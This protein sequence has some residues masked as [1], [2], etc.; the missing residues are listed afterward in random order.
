MLIRIVFLFCFLLLNFIWGQ[1]KPNV[2]MIIVDDLNDLPLHPE[3]KPQAKTPNIDR[4]SKQ[5]VNF[6]N[7]HCNNP[8]CEPSRNSLF[9]G[10]YPQT[11]GLHWFEHS[12]KNEILKNS[13]P[14]QEHLQSNGYQAFGT[15]KIFHST[16]RNNSFDEWG[17]D[18]NYGPWP[19][20]GRQKSRYGFL[21]HPSQSDFLKASAD[22]PF[23]WEHCFGT[24]EKVPHWAPDPKNNIPGYKG[25][26]L[27]TEPWE[28]DSNGKRDLVADELSAQW[29]A[30]K[31]RRKSKQPFALF[32]GLTKTHTPLYAP[33]SYF[34]RYPLDEIKIPKNWNY[35]EQNLG[36][37]E[38][39]KLYGFRRYEM[40]MKYG[41]ELYLK[42]WIQAYLACLSFV[43]DQVGI[44]LDA[45][46]S[47][48]HKD[49][50]VVIFTSD[51][52]FHM[53]DKDFLYKGSLWESSTKIPLLISGVHG[54]DKGVICQKPVS[55]IDLYPTFVDLCQLP[56]NPNSKKSGYDLDGHSLVPLLNKKT[57][58]NWSG[59][60]VAIT[61][62]AGEDHMHLTN[63]IGIPYPSFSV[64]SK[65]W[66]L[67][68]SSSG[69][70]ALY[71]TGKDHYE[72][73]DLSKDPMF[74]EKK[75]EL[76]SKLIS[77]KDG[78][79]WNSLMPKSEWKLK[80]KPYKE[81][82]RRDLLEFKTQGSFELESK[83]NYKSFEIEFEL[84]SKQV[85]HF[86]KAD[87]SFMLQNKS[88]SGIWS[89]ITVNRNNWNHFK[90][91]VLGDRYQLWINHHLFL[92]KRSESIK[93]E[94]SIKI[95]TDST[96]VE[97]LSFR[98]MRL[99]KL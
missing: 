25:W 84:K 58:E 8:V 71:H 39:K 9:F 1:Q 54:M 26:T 15:G 10:L 7:A 19:W 11:T 52:G 75:L 21:P 12:E 29:A 34:D 13:T 98:G 22:V 56:Q 41:G 83:L 16:R 31:L 37:L 38:D 61:S 57:K 62:L 70:E 85:L 28:F 74:Y 73:I 36:K 59:P 44:L 72:Q 5:G 18:L 89:D 67:I 76:K 24:F 65:A 27:Y 35:I 47:S 14:L 78:K 90:I 97:T 96:E 77:L 63:R 66:R 95:F 69:E 82:W 68:L 49:N 3:F 30:N 94:D 91:N 6:T 40:L 43:D 50:T 79:K 88:F 93:R 81:N 53:G 20:D 45:L 99:K 64:K 2:L 87:E 92:D 86:Q 42:K 51:H 48:P 17:H 32:V 23:A 4:I 55:L 80:I 46:E 60:E 33:K